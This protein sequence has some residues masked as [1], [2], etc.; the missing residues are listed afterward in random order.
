MKN[1]LVLLLLLVSGAFSVAQENNLREPDPDNLI[2]ELF[3]QQDLPANYE[4]I[5][6]ALYQYYLT[7]LNLNRA[8]REELESLYILNPE[9]INSF[10]EYKNKYGA[11][12]SIYELQAIP[13]WEIITIRKI[14]TFVEVVEAFDLEKFRDRFLHNQN[15]YLLFRTDRV[16]EKRKGY[17]PDEDGK[18]AYAGSPYKYLIRYKNSVSRDF[19]IGLTME[20]DP[21][22]KLKWNTEEREYLMDYISFHACLFNKGKWKAIGIGDYKI[23]FGQGLV[24]GGGFYMGKSA[25]TILSVKKNSRGVLPYSSVME[26]DFFRGICF[27]YSVFKNTDLTGFYSNNNRDAG[28]RY[29]TLDRQYVLSSFDNYGMH[30]TAAEIRSKKNLNE[31]A[32]GGN[33][34]FCS[35]NKKFHSGISYVNT[36]YSKAVQETDRIYN[37]FDFRGKENQVISADYSWVIQNLNLFGETAVCSSGGKA[38]VAGAIASLSSKIDLSYLYRNYNKNFHSFYSG[39]FSEGS[40]TNNEKGNYWGLRIKLNGKWMISAYYDHFAFPWLKY[41]KDSPTSGYGYLGRCQYAPSKKI[42]LYFQLRYEESGKN[43]SD[44]YTNIDFTVPSKKYNYMINLDYKSGI[45]SLRSRVQWSRYQ[46]SNAATHGF[47]VVQDLNIDLRKI[48]F[49]TRYALFDTEDYDNRQ[50]VYEK[51]VLYA[52]SFPAYNGRGIRTYLITQFKCGKRID[53]WLRY[54]HT[55]YLDQDKIGSGLDEI[56]G[57]KISELKIQIRYRF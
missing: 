22:E 20:K 33:F 37:R 10:F 16:I 21:G 55:K 49:S 5:Y 39:A 35:D 31:Q 2:Q 34:S 52:V 45:I 38:L 24:F 8:G 4:D 11:L 44:N 54:S 42:L 9:E 40:G 1:N 6:D 29:D 17:I 50:Y 18:T 26:T 15:H 27:T 48:K 23:Q 7:P 56:K 53:L 25:E 41:F 32:M 19:S 51:D 57:N 3:R 28:L 47:V 13:N 36:I 14:L 43:Q 12:V 30:R 46:Q